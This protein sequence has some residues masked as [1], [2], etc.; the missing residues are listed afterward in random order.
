M[1]YNAELPPFISIVL[2]PVRT[3]SEYCSAR[4]SRVVLSTKQATEPYSD[5]LFNRTRT[6][7][8]THSDDEIP[9]KKSFEAVALLVGFS[10]GNPPKIG[11]FTASNRTRNRTR[12]PPDRS[13]SHIGHRLT[14]LRGA[15]AVA[16]EITFLGVLLRNPTPKHDHAPRLAFLIYNGFRI[17]RHRNRAVEL[18]R[19]FGIMRLRPPVCVWMR[20]RAR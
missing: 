13:S 16:Y 15:S 7:S 4:V 19:W 9:L 11:T 10:T 3:V 1:K 14:K 5:N 2:T 18:L 17:K 6:P 12:T 20:D 8:E